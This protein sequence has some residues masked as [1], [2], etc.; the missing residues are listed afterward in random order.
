MHEKVYDDFVSGAVA[1]TKQYVLGNPTEQGTTLGPVVRTAAAEQVRKQIASS[2]HAGAQAALDERSFPLSRA[3]TP[4]V[5]PQL[6]LNAGQGA[7]R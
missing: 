6:L 5:A 2:I 7:A 4:Y 1:L 3:G